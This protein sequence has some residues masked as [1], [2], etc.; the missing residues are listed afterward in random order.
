MLLNFNPVQFVVSRNK[1]FNPHFVTEREV[2]EF[3]LRGPSFAGVT[4]G[5]GPERVGGSMS[6]HFVPQLS[7]KRNLDY[8]YLAKVCRSFNWVQSLPVRTSAFGVK[9]V[10]PAVEE[11]FDTD[12]L[13]LYMHI[14][15]LAV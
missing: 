11:L 5:N 12:A 13:K 9:K 2:L 15:L 1:V 8:A 4:G 10:N 3:N 6:F 7:R 14:C